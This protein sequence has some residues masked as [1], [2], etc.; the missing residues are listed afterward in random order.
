MLILDLAHLKNLTSLNITGTNYLTNKLFQYLDP[1]INL[2]V[3][4]VAFCNSSINIF[5]KD[6]THIYLWNHI[7]NCIQQNRKNYELVIIF[8]S[9]PKDSNQVVAQN[10]N[11]TYDQNKRIPLHIHLESTL[12]SFNEYYHILSYDKNGLSY[13]EEFQEELSQLPLLGCIQL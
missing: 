11:L 8:S 13:L 7:K 12:N 10:L 9:L 2:T 3:F 4:R 6:N 5:S 1:L